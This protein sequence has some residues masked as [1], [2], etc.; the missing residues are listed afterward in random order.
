MDAEIIL[1]GGQQLCGGDL[2]F[3]V[4]PVC[5]DWQH[6]VLYI[7]VYLFRRLSIRHNGD[8]QS[9]LYIGFSIRGS[10]H[11]QRIHPVLYQRQYDEFPWHIWIDERFQ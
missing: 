1:H 4:G 8:E 9:G 2:R 6:G 10:V 11:N 7:S 3:H 5:A